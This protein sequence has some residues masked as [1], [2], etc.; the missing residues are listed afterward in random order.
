[1]EHI[2]KQAALLSLPFY[3]GEDAEYLLRK[4][5]NPTFKEEKKKKDLCILERNSCK[6]QLLSLIVSLR[7]Q[8]W[9]KRE[10]STSREPGSRGCAGLGWFGAQQW[11][12]H[13]ALLGDQSM[14]GGT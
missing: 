8:C 1:M 13:A 10:L 3:S 5:Q 12:E 4:S 2:Q 11:K 6:V 7:A 14:A 9:G